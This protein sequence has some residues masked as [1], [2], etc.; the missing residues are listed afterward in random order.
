MPYA[1]FS[2]NASVL[3]FPKALSMSRK[4]RRD[5]FGHNVTVINCCCYCKPGFHAQ[6]FLN[7][8]K[9]HFG[10]SGKFPFSALRRFGEERLARATDKSLPHE[11]KIENPSAGVIFK[12][13][14]K[15]AASGRKDNSDVFTLQLFLVYFHMNS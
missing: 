9:Q 6:L 7:L 4:A 14:G 12:S 1:R 11:R 10:S 2:R 5:P 3:P 13:S 15:A 8:E